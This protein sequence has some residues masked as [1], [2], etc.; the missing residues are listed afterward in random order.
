MSLDGTWWSRRWLE[1]IEEP[2]E[3]R[4][5]VR[6]GRVTAK[7]GWVK[8]ISVRPGLVTA[9]VEE[10][11]GGHA[12]VRLRQPPIE[13]AIWTRVIKRLGNEASHAA[14]LLGGR[15]TE[16]MVA[17]FEEAGAELFP[18]DH[19]DLTYFCT[20][21]EDSAVCRHGVALHFALSEAMVA[22]P[23]VLFEFRGKDRDTLLSSLRAARN[24]EKP[25]KAADAGEKKAAVAAEAALELE[26]ASSLVGGFWQ[27]GVIPHLAFRLGTADLATEE[28]FPVVRALGPGPGET[29]PE[30]IAQALAPIARMAR[31]RAQEIVEQVVEDE[32]PVPA[33][34][35]KGE[36]EPS[37]DELLVAAAWQHGSLT[38]KMV[39]DALGIDQLDARKYLKWLVEEGRLQQ[40]GK[41]RGTRYFPP[42]VELPKDAGDEGEAEGSATPAAPS[43]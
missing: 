1:P 36:A 6:K 23:F 13:D 2:K 17:F 19:H 9:T 8:G 40:V 28:A 7:R 38:S 3:F 37:L 16:E 26:D 33:A 5:Q 29:S 4:Q 42:G 22:D 18:F 39:S 12:S 15:I 20:C 24:G 10:D 31:K 21:S 41:A 43:T 30:S 25:A 34:L 14:M 11:I 35:P 32:T 27:A